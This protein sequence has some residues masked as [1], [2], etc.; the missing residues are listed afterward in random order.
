MLPPLANK[1]VPIF[2]ALMFI[3]TAFTGITNWCVDS[4]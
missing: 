2:C 1:T 4:R 3:F